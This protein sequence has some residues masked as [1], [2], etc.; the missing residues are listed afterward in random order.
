MRTRCSGSVRPACFSGSGRSDLD[1]S[2]NRSAMMDSSPRLEV[3]TSPSTP[4]W[5]PRSMSRF[6]DSRASAPTL[7][8]ESMTW[9][10]PLPS[11][12]VAQLLRHAAYDAV[13]LAGEAEDDAGLQRLDG[14]LADDVA[15]AYE[16]DLVQLG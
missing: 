13:D 3:M 6:Q 11:R 14:V 4:T 8:S 16:L 7:A 12:V 9:M 15:G 10:S 5:S 2:A 1:V